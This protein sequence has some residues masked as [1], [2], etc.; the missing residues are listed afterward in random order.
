MVGI[1]CAA[2]LIGLVWGLLTKRAV[3]G[4]CAGLL[5]G[6]GNYA[7]WTAYNAITD[8]LGLDTVANL[9]TNLGLFV[10]LGVV[11]G[12]AA[13]CWVARPAAEK[14]KERL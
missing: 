8:K 6:T 4:F 12:L 11:V 14:Q 9:L 5:V 10:V 3:R 13:G 1:L 2:P 7:L